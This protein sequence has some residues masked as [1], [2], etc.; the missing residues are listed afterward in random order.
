MSSMYFNFLWIQY[1][2]GAITEVHLDQA[3]VKGYIT[4]GEKQEIME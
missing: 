3:V 1:R 4:E 2:L